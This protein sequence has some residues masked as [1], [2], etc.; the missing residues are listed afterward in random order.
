MSAALDSDLV[1]W[2][3]DDGDYRVLLKTVE[4]NLCIV[5]KNELVHPISQ[6]DDDVYDA[7]IAVVERFYAQLLAGDVQ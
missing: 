5:I 3:D 7:I 1:V 4:P 6:S 2:K